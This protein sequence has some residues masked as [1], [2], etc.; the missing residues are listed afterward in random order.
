VTGDVLSKVNR[1]SGVYSFVTGK[2]TLN[3][4]VTD[5]FLKGTRAHLKAQLISIPHRFLFMGT[6]RVGGEDYDQQDKGDDQHDKG[7]EGNHELAH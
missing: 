2:V 3:G 6:F 4:V 1:L 7:K 5:G